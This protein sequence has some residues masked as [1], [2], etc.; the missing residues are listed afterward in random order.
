MVTDKFMNIGFRD[1]FVPSN[2]MGFYIYLHNRIDISENYV[3]QHLKVL[4][5]TIFTVGINPI[6]VV[7]HNLSDCVNRPFEFCPKLSNTYLTS[8]FE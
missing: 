1:L 7:R 2:Q 6:F 4:Y 8:Y 3:A 5:N